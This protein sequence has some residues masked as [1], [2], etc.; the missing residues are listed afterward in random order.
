MANIRFKDATHNTNED[1]HRHAQDGDIIFLKDNFS[2]MEKK[3]L[4]KAELN[5]KLANT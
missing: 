5:T 3:T 4:S 1:N 2:M